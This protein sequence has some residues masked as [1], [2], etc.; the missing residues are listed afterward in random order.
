LF[1]KTVPFPEE[2]KKQDTKRKLDSGERNR[3]QA[4]IMGQGFMQNIQSAKNVRKK[5]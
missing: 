3:L 2:R 1:D 4:E 5:R